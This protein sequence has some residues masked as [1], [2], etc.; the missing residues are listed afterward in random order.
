[1][2]V[3][4]RRVC[5]ARDAMTRT[6][7]S[8]GESALSPACIVMV[9]RRGVRLPKLD[10]EPSVPL[11]EP[12]LLLIERLSA[13]GPMLLDGALDEIATRTNS[14]RATLEELFGRS[15]QAA[16]AGRPRP[17]DRERTRAGSARTGPDPGRHRRPRADPATPVPP[18]GGPIRVPRSPRSCPRSC[19][20]S[21]APR[22]SGVRHTAV[23][24][25]RL[26]EDAGLARQRSLT[27]GLRPRPSLDSGRHSC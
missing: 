2:A 7:V 23:G 6:E 27:C 13:S 26:R 11:G 4:L 17:A 19:H 18:Q 1:M 14:S 24:R 25:C 8:R 21:R 5:E 15:T 20:R 16:L 22:R 9:T 3:T 10:D 12:A